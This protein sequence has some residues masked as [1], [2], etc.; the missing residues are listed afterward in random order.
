MVPTT[1][2]AR[3]ECGDNQEAR[4]EIR[5][6]FADAEIDFATP[7]PT[8]LIQRILQ[9]ATGPD[10]L[11]LDAFAG[12]GTTAHAVLKQNALDGGNRRFVLVEMEDKVARPVTAERV[13]RAVEGYAFSGND[14]VELLR[15]KLSYTKLKRADK[16]LE[17]VDALKEEHAD[18]FDRFDVK[19]EKDHLVL[20]GVRRVEEK[21]EGLGGGFRFAT[22]GPKVFDAE[23]R[24]R[25]DI[26]YDE[27]APFVFFLATGRPLEGAPADPPFLGVSGGVGVYLLYNG[28]LKDRSRNGGNVLTRAVL[29]ELP[30]HDGPR[31]VYGTATTLST[32]RLEGMGIQFRQIPYALQQE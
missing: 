7:K 24:I 22:L 20:T 29:A 31:V 28:V 3:E 27:L 32:A 25:Q 13:R 18:R 14:R 16:L 19:V 9:I 26:R 10:D 17:R 2:W 21:K 5:S 6:I 12:S 23:G 30:A 11:V 1:W 15:E 8:R 4:R